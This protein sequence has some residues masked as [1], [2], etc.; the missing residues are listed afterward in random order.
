MLKSVDHYYPNA[1]ELSPRERMTRVGTETRVLVRCG[2]L[3]G[4]QSFDNVHE[5]SAAIADTLA[6]HGAGRTLQFSV[7][8]V[9]KY[10][11][12]SRD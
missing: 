3:F 11:Y 4:Q 7:K 12:K 2:E 9:I 6:K 10:E 8:E 1:I 5:A